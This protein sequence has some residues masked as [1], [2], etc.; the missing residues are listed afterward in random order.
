M[1][2]HCSWI[3][4]D[5]SEFIELAN[6]RFWIGIQSLHYRGEE[7]VLLDT[8]CLNVVASFRFEVQ[9]VQS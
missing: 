1:N 9:E 5:S 7:L 6:D 8:I 3:S 4:Y 2:T